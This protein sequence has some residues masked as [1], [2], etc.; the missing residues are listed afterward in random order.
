[1]AKEKNKNTTKSFVMLIV[2]GVVLVAVTL[3]WF[4][5]NKISSVGELD[6]NVEPSASAKAKLYYGYYQEP[7]QVAI[8]KD[9]LTGYAEISG[10]PITLENMIPGAEYF[11]KAEFSSFTGTKDI[12][13]SFTDVVDSG[14]ASAVTVYSRYTDANDTINHPDDE[15]LLQLKKGSYQVMKETVSAG[16]YVIYFSFKF[17]DD[18]TVDGYANKSVMIGSV[19]AIL[20]S[21]I[22]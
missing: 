21:E 6:S 12:S 4:A 16:T 2:T 10:E 17:D 3:C 15:N 20:G 18:A 22:I 13:L 8:S 5:I 19:D 9:K 14:L 7:S 1:M 11:F